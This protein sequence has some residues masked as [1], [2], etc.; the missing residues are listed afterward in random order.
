MSLAIA[1]VEKP[2]G[3]AFSPD[4]S[5]LY[6]SDTAPAKLY[7]YRLDAEGNAA[8]ERTVFDF[9]PGRGIDGMEVDQN[10]VIY[11][12]AGE[13]ELSGIYA[14]SPAGE[15]LEFIPVPETATNCAFGG[16]GGRTLFITAGISLYR[17]RVRAPGQV[18]FP[19]AWRD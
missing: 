3:L 2:N 8:R 17:I 9:S 12:A 7:A 15:L 16:A 18:L 11:G 6:V 14:I 19:P 4:G 10:G 13:G 5:T 1:G